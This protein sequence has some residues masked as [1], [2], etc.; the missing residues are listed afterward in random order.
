MKEQPFNPHLD[1][2]ELIAYVRAKLP[3]GRRR[4]VHAHL[5][6]RDAASPNQLTNE[7]PEILAAIRCQEARR[8][9]TG[10]LQ[11]SKGRAAKQISPYLGPKATAGVLQGVSADCRN[12]LSELQPILSLF[13]GRRAAGRLSTRAVE[14]SIMRF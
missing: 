14:A 13:L 3:H 8:S 4:E 12:L 11:A 5:G 6:I 7:L 10:A 9:G 1:E 2:R